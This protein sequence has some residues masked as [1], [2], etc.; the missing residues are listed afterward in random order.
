MIETV[1]KSCYVNDPLKVVSSENKA[2]TLVQ[3]LRA[4][5]AKRGFRLTKWTSNNLAVL[6]SLPTEEKEKEVKELEL[7]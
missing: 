5:C 1:K 3:D 7:D 6:A 2:I 4:I